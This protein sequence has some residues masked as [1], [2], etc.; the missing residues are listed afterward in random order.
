MMLQITNLSSGYGSVEVLHGVSLAV[1]ENEIVSVLGAN[2][3]GK[4]TLLR[5]VSGLIPVKSGS[6]HYLGRD[7]TKVPYDELVRNGLIHVPEGRDIF[8]DLTVLENLELG[9]FYWRRDRRGVQKKLKEVF[10]IFPRLYERKG[11]KAGSLSGGEQQMLAIG[12]GLM[13]KPKLLMLDEPSLGLSPL[14]VQ[15]IFKVIQNLLAQGLSVLLVEQNA[16]SALKISHRAYVIQNG[17]IVQEGRAAQL[18]EDETIQQL[19]LGA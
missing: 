18:L 12:R 6:I 9:A 13:S 10:E 19:Y 2:G 15:E 14:L 17:R 5:T 4:S 7:I 16:K 8:T 11:Q 3:A 1:H